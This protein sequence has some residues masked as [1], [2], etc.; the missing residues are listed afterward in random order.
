VPSLRVLVVDVEGRKECKINVMYFS[1]HMDRLTWRWREWMHG[2]T[3]IKAS[4]Y[5]HVSA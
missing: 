2:E 3:V 1:L 4:C 5:K